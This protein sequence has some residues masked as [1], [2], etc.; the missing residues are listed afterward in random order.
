MWLLALVPYHVISKMRKVSMNIA[1]LRVAQEPTGSLLNRILPSGC[2]VCPN[3]RGELRS[4]ASSCEMFMKI[5]HG[6]G[7]QLI[8]GVCNYHNDRCNALLGQALSLASYL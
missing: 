4:I 8:F 1:Y 6:K 7:T 5:C 3:G 2:K